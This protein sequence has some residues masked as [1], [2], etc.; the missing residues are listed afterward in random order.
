MSIENEPFG[1]ISINANGLA[2]SKRRCSVFGWLKKY[3]GAQKKI[4]FVQETHSTEKI[5]KMWENEWGNHHDVYFS[6]GSSSSRG[7]AIVI[8]RALEHKI[9]QV[10]R[11]QNGR[12]IMINIT[13]KENTFC[14]INCYAPTIDK[15][16]EQL[17]WLEKIQEIL[18]NNSD[19]HIIVGGDLNDCFIPILDRYNCKPGAIETEY[20]KAWK[21]ICDEL[22]LAD[23]WRVINPERKCYTWRQGKSAAT[24]RQSR[25]DYWLVSVHMFYDLQEVDI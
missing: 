5:E 15:P 9:N 2:D 16:K 14:L 7:V 13:I 19:L 21:T 3:H 6:H 1:L 25:L 10:I 18:Q 24:L 22:N 11:S 4:T 12:Y 17:E 8:P 20:V 23:I